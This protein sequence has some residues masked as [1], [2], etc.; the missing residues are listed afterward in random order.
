MSREIRGHMTKKDYNFQNA[1]QGRS[2]GKDLSSKQSREWFRD[3]AMGVKRINVPKFQKETTPFQNIE[4]LSANSIG[5]MYHFTYDPKWKD[6]L[7]YYDTF[8]LV[9]PFDFKGDRML[10]INMHYLSPY[11]R[12]RL[13]DALY[14]TLN[15]EKYDKT[16]KLQVSYGILK[17]SFRFAAF[18]PCIHCYLFDHVRSPFMYITPDMWDYTLMLPTARFQ[19]HSADYVWLQSNL[20][21]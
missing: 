4:N 1:A 21:W 2:T 11:L 19:K 18:R 6:K 15:N 3:L 16:T 12:A 13:M 8:P 7:P 10:G 20:K 17:S 9:F 14:T 5:K